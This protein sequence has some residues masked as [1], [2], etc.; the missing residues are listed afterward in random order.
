ME[1]STLQ[2]IVP[3]SR[4]SAVQKALMR[5]F[6]T[7]DVSDISLVAGGLSNAPVYKMTVNNEAYILKLGGTRGMANPVEEPYVSMEIAANAGIAPPLYYL[8]T[9]DALSITKFIENKPLRAVFTSPD[10]LLGKLAKT[11]RSIHEM[12]R[13]PKE[14]SLWTLVENLMQQVRGTPM[15]TNAVFEDFFD[16]YEIIRLCYPWDDNDK[17]SSHNDLNPGNIL[18]DGNRIWIVDWD[19]AHLNDRYVDLAIS[20]NSFVRNES[21]EKLFLEAYFGDELNSYKSARFFIMRQICRLIYAALM[22]K[23]AYTSD[24]TCDLDDPDL[25]TVNMQKIGEQISSGKL[26][27]SSY[28]GQLFYGKAMINEALIDM[29]SPRFYLSTDT[30]MA[31]LDGGL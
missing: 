9:E 2:S 21:Q 25:Q 4:L 29:R 20:A 28:K 8:N 6:N 18:C 22:F 14:N 13:L 15:Y 11:I 10:V 7:A 30:L 17:V 12:P 24:P 19:A 27:I 3:A 1:P 31:G 5:A 16:Y 23:L 26:S